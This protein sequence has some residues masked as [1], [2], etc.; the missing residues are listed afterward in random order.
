MCAGGRVLVHSENQRGAL[1]VTWEDIDDDDVNTPK[2]VCEQ[3]KTIEGLKIEYHRVP[4][5]PEAG[6]LYSSKQ[7]MLHF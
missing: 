2:D 1:H 3:I 6:T 4:M 7:K 5:T